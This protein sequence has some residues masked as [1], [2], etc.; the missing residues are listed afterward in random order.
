MPKKV[1]RWFIYPLSGETNAF[2]AGILDANVSMTEIRCADHRRRPV[3]V[4]DKETVSLVRNSRPGS[5]L[6]F[7]VYKEFSDGKI[8]QD[9]NKDQIKQR[10]GNMEKLKAYLE[11]MRPRRPERSPQTASK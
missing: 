4:C 11:S 9:R 1:I 6:K 3:W 2:M 5:G 10:F 7:I 8:H